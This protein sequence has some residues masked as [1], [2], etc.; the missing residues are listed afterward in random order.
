LIISNFG[1]DWYLVVPLVF[2]TSVGSEKDPG[3]VRFPF[4]S[5]ILNKVSTMRIRL[6]RSIVPAVL[7]VGGLTS[8]I[9]GVG[10]HS[11][12][13]LVEEE[14]K[15]MVDVPIGLPAPDMT[16]DASPGETSPNGASP[17]EGQPM[18]PGAGP[19]GDNPFGG[20]PGGN[21]F[22][23]PRTVKKEVSRIDLVT[24]MTGEP[25]LMREVSVGGVIRLDNGDLKR[26]YSGEG[27]SLCPS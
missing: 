15:T 13:V 8:L 2:K 17:P 18:M 3:W 10:H 1:G 27:P 9:Y 11:R 7:L 4:T 16:G 26:T 22:G 12:G 5:A 23:P 19:G 24:V 6:R 21:P 20:P 25:R 14:T